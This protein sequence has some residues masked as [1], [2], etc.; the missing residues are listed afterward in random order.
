M[1]ANS[2]V[3][4]IAD[5]SHTLAKIVTGVLTVEAAQQQSGRAGIDVHL[6]AVLAIRPIVKPRAH[7][8]VRMAVAVEVACRSNHGRVARRAELVARRLTVPSPDQAAGRAG[9]D[10]DASAV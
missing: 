5:R 9:V 7:D 10:V 8:Q 3:V 4:E 1:I 2:V 6:P